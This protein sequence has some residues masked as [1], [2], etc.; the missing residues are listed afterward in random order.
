MNLTEIHIKFA[1]MECRE[2]CPYF[3]YVMNETIKK[4]NQLFIIQY[5][6]ILMDP[7]DP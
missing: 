1:L 6:E 3:V 4:D 2:L 7:F 5:I